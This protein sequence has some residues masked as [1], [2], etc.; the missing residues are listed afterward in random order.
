MEE[1]ASVDEFHRVAD[2]GVGVPVGTPLR[3]GRTHEVRRGFVEDLVVARWG[4]Q[5]GTTSA[6]V[7]VHQKVVVVVSPEVLLAQADNDL[8]SGRRRPTLPAGAG[9][10]GS[11]DTVSD[12]PAGPVDVRGGR[13]C[14]TELVQS[15]PAIEHPATGSPGWRSRP[16]GGAAGDIPTAPVVRPADG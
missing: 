11:R 1:V 5:L 3:P 12:V 15:P 6:H 14:A 13:G 9:R 2:P 4:W 7:G 16:H 10:P 8:V